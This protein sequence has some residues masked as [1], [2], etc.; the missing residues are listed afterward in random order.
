M[1]QNTSH[2]HKVQANHTCDQGTKYNSTN[3]KSTTSYDQNT[4]SGLELPPTLVNTPHP[5]YHC[6][7][8]LPPHQLITTPHLLRNIS[9]P[10]RLPFHCTQTLHHYVLSLIQPAHPQPLINPF[11]ILKHLH[12]HHKHISLLFPASSSDLNPT[13]HT[14]IPRMDASEWHKGA[15]LRMTIFFYRK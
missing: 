8:P 15:Q 6:H 7:S 3:C 10:I 4:K 9:P 12:L 5:A 1:L 2:G 14:S 11:I 13:P